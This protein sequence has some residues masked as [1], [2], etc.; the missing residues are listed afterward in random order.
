MEVKRMLN[1][2][3]LGPG[4]SNCTKLYEVTQK[5]V[6][7]LGIEAELTKVSDYPEMMKYGLLQTPGLVVEEQL[8][9]SGKVPSIAEVTTILTTAVAKKA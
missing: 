1:V 4:C 6:E 2:K 5:A 7:S 8:V 9:L 3:I